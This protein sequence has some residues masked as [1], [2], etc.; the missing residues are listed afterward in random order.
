MQGSD[1]VAGKYE[2]GFK[3]WECSY[4]LCHVI[5]DAFGLQGQGTRG[6][7]AHPAAALMDKRVVELG[8]GHGLP[9]ILCLLAGAP[10][11]VLQDYNP[12]VIEHLT[13][14]NVI[15]NLDRIDLEEN[16]GRNLGGAAKGTRTS[17]KNHEE[18]R[19]DDDDDDDDGDGGD[20]NRDSLATPG[21]R[22]VSGDWGQLEDLLLSSPGRMDEGGRGSCGLYDVVLSSETI[23]SQASM[24][25][26]WGLIRK[27]R[28]IYHG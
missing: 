2:G 25:R 26:L 3:L 7:P 5:C 19:D 16:R 9:G 21:V 11:V 10:D 15:L 1:L 18:Q 24:K 23:Y 4:D 12:E 20:D 28:A 6:L 22:L 13:G 8:C 27:V 17:Q 14:P